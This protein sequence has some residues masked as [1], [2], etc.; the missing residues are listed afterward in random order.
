MGLVN[1][2]E[3]ARLLGLSRRTLDR[4]KDELLRMGQAVMVGSRVMYELD[5]LREVMGGLVE[6]QPA[7]AQW[8]AK[9]DTLQARAKAE[10]EAAASSGQIPEYGESRAKREHYLARLA[11]L[12]VAQT[13][14]RLMDAEQVK[15]EWFEAGRRVRN[16]M[17]ALAHRLAPDLAPMDDTTE[18]GIFLEK[19]MAE[20]LTALAND[21]RS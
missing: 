2:T 4:K 20:G 14:E 11:E 13:E 5:G 3:A 6:H 15:A 8:L 7:N 17:A 19:Q 12:Q 1:Q 10:T 16:W 9:G 18:I 21:L